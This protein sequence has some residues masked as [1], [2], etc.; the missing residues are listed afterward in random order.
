MLGELDVAVDCIVETA[1]RLENANETQS[2]SRNGYAHFHSAGVAPV[3]PERDNG[4]AVR[5]TDMQTRSVHPRRRQSQ[6]DSVPAKKQV[7]AEAKCRST[8]AAYRTDSH[9]SKITQKYA[10]GQQRDT[11]TLRGAGRRSG[12]GRHEISLESSAISPDDADEASE[13]GCRKQPPIARL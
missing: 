8:A 2:P 6:P 11:P 9:T 10:C 7:T 12:I 13:L 1:E 4:R 3:R 5:V